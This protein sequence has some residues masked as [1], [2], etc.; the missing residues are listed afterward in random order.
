[1]R[2]G[3]RMKMGMKVTVKV[4]VGMGMRMRKGME[5]LIGGERFRTPK[6]VKISTLVRD[7]SAARCV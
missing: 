4:R 2:V 1:M 3:M 6:S 7:R 5:M